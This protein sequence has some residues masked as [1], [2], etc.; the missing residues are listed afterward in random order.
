MKY[1]FH[2]QENVMIS[3]TY[4]LEEHWYEKYYKR[5]GQPDVDVWDKALYSL[6]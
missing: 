1:S 3:S 5:N 4:I 2:E 6:V